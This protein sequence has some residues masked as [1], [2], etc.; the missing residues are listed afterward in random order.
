MISLK[1]KR[2]SQYDTTMEDG[3]TTRTFVITG[4]D[5]RGLVTQ[6]AGSSMTQGR[7]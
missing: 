4:K 7:S 5:H 3:T 2:G 1:A 6:E